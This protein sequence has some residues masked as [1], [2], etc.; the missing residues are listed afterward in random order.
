MS[1]KHLK[2]NPSVS[3]VYQR[4]LT[5][6][7]AELL[8]VERK[9]QQPNRDQKH[10]SEYSEAALEPHTI[11]GQKIKTFAPFKYEFSA[12]RT[13]TRS[14]FFVIA[15]IIFI[16]IFV[17][18][19]NIGVF[20]IIVTTISAFVYVIHFFL[21]LLLSAIPLTRPIEE[22]LDDTAIREL[23][24]FEWPRYT[25]LCPLYHEA[26]VVPQFTEAM[27]KL[28]YPPNK[29]QIL[30]LTE[31]GD[32]ETRN[33]IQAMN[34]SSYFHVITVPNGQ[35][36]TKPRACN[37]GLLQAIGEYIV[38]YD[39]ED[40]PDPLQLKK[41]VLAFAHN[42]ASTVCV[43]AKL[44]FYNVQQNILTRWFTAEYSLLFDLTLPGLQVT[45]L[46]IPLGGT[47]NHFRRETLCKLGAWDAFNVTEDCDLG[48]RLAYNNLNTIMLDS[49]TYEEANSQ[50]KN[51]LRQRSRWMK[52][53]MQTYL[54]YM[55]HPFQYVQLKRLREFFSL[56]LVVGG[57]AAAYMANGIL[58]ILLFVFLYCSW[59][60]RSIH[61]PSLALYICAV[62]LIIGNLSYI[63]AYLI[64]C[65]KRRQYKL[66]KWMLLLPFYVALTSIATFIALYQLIFKPH[67]WEKTHHGLHLSRQK[68]HEY[69]Q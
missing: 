10:M 60:S 33:C 25:V 24:E 32:V 13:I 1:Y 50:L 2:T 64:G 21:V 58:S 27:R 31:E 16:L 9:R 12:F 68:E 28:E 35:P 18:L 48:I 17:L 56:Q 14:Q 67:Y 51:W 3:K 30:F 15:I 39:A 45:K 6:K 47:S 4:E 11:H 66:I 49:T 29:L 63:G 22:R 54:V 55:R 20:I 46:S 69:L 52:G 40:I 65:I 57:K 19:L 37:Y 61:F 26:E 53:Y 23:S 62:G 43:Q 8:S 36:R 42:D 7:Y 5:V 44:N 41:A 38:I 59:F 34:L